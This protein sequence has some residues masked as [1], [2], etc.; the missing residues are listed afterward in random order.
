LFPYIV[1]WGTVP[2]SLL[3]LDHSGEK[4]A[5]T[6]VPKLYS[7]L[8]AQLTLQRCFW[9]QLE[10][11]RSG[12]GRFCGLFECAPRPSGQSVKPQGNLPLLW[13]KIDSIEL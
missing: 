4:A 10:A 13:L 8:Q 9:K 7:F 11:H 6:L 2:F 1:L 3:S 12:L 5:E